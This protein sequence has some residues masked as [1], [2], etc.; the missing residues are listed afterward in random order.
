[1]DN[2]QW[3]LLIMEELTA[4]GPRQPWLRSRVVPQI[5]AF[6]YYQLSWFLFVLSPSRSY[7]LNADFEDHAEPHDARLVAEHPDRE[8]QPD[9]PST[10]ACTTWKARRFCPRR[11]SDDLYPPPHQL[12]AGYTAN[13]GWGR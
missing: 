10:T 3:H 12:V 13:P 11:A 4:S 7:R 6:A 5:L 9:A 8:E 1:Q 2:E